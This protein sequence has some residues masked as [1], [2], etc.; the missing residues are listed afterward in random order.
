MLRGPRSWLQRPECLT[1]LFRRRVADAVPLYR[2]FGCRPWVPLSVTGEQRARKCTS[3]AWL[4]AFE[5]CRR[6][7]LRVQA[8]R[9]RGA[10]ESNSGSSRG[11]AAG[12][13]R[14]QENPACEQAGFRYKA[15][16]P[17]QHRSSN[18]STAQETCAGYRAFVCCARAIR[19]PRLRTGGFRY[20]ALKPDQHRSSNANTAQ[21]TCAGYR[22][23]ACGARAIKNPTRLVG[24]GFGIKRS[25]MTYSCMA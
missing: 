4:S 5:R 6:P 24:W 7:I 10:Q 19:K 12:C 22:A 11:C 13:R 23:F 14:P 2:R 17:D 8:N 16:K 20:K 9:R 3:A 21:E 1:H 18:A 25:A 15:L